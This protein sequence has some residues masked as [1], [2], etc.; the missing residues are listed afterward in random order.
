MFVL[1]SSRAFRCHRKQVKRRIWISTSKRRDR[2]RGGRRFLHH[3]PSQPRLGKRYC[4]VLCLSCFCFPLRIRFCCSYYRRSPSS[5]CMCF[6]GMR[7]G[8]LDLRYPS[9]LRVSYCSSLTRGCEVLAGVSAI[10]FARFAG[11][12]CP[13]EWR[14]TERHV[15]SLPVTHVV[16]LVRCCLSGTSF[17]R[18]SI[19]SRSISPLSP[20]RP[21]HFQMPPTADI[22]RTLQSAV[23]ELSKHGLKLSTKW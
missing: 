8:N 23:E 20:F 10:G 4:L 12:R 18:E 16:Y 13:F 7:C 19:I 1:F 17:G 2:G 6:P 11:P 15:E 14:W 9:H 22:R 3:S 21:L 5:C